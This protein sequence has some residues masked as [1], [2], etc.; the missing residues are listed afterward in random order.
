MS[1]IFLNSIFLQQHSLSL[2]TKKVLLSI[3]I[4]YNIN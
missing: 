2:I 4:I 1:N 3:L